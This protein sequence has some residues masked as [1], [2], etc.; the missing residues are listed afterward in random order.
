MLRKTITLIQSPQRSLEDLNSNVLKVHHHPRI[1]Q[2]QLNHSLM[3][4]A[5]WIE[6]FGELGRGLAVDRELEIVALRDD[7]HIVPIAFANVVESDG[8]F[9]LGQRGRVVFVNHQ[10]VTA[11]AGVLHSA[12]RM[13][14]PCSQ[15]LFANADMA[16]IGVITLESS[17]PRFVF[18]STYVHSAIS[19][20]Q[21]SITQFEFEVC[22]LFLVIDQ[23]AAP[24]IF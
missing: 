16:D 14:V 15:Y 22:D 18:A 19:F 4:A 7:V 20:P 21:E 9:N 11:K 1:V 13:E 5:F 24:F 23:I 8:A 6:M 10:S 12:R 17:G 3:Q 2:L